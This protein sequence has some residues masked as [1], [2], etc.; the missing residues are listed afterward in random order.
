MR[1]NCAWSSD[2]CS[3]D[4]FF[5]QAEDGIRYLYVTGVQ[6]C[7]LPI[8]TS[9][10]HERAV[11]VR[12]AVAVERPEVADFLELGHVEVGRASCRERVY[13]S[14]VGVEIKKEIRRSEE[15]RV[16]TECTR[17]GS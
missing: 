4:L 15:R 16:G 8:W 12:A 7:A 14:V 3:S 10:L 6:T 9:G 11:A 2:L 13:S 5:F 17:T 1:W